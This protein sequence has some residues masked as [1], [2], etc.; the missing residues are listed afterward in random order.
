MLANDSHVSQLR[1]LTITLTNTSTS[2]SALMATAALAQG[3]SVNLG[4]LPDDMKRLTLM[5]NVNG[6]IAS[7]FAASSASPALVAGLP[8]A[9]AISYK[10]ALGIN[11]IS[12]AGGGCDVWIE[13]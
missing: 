11:L 4:L 5:P 2:L 6:H 1:T 13:A 12:S 10:L 7:G 9:F 8:Y 3:L